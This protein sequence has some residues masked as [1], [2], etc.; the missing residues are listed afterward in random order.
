MAISQLRYKFNTIYKNHTRCIS[1]QQ[2]EGLAI[3]VIIDY[4]PKINQ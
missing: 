3:I 2:F 4:L 1:K